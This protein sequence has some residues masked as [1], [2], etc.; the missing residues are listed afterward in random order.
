MKHIIS[1]DLEFGENS[2][3]AVK[4]YLEEE[5]YEVENTERCAITDY[6][7][8][9]PNW[10][11][12]HVELKTRRN[13]VS[14]YPTTMIGLNKVEKAVELYEKHWEKT[15]FLFSF[16]DWLYYIDPLKDKYSVEEKRGR[17][18]RGGFDKV[19]KWAYY[20]VRDLVLLKKYK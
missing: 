2:E 11:K 19:K 14:T 20:D 4:L 12:S 7:L 15:R 9:C 3:D 1:K 18:D 8:T 17:F 6:V 16:T 13:S 10:T 5:W